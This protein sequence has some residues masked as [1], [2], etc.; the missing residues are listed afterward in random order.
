MQFLKTRKAQRS[1]QR[2]A[3]RAAGVKT[4]TGTL[5]TL[6]AFLS[7]VAHGKHADEL[8]TPELLGHW[9]V[10][11]PD[12][13]SGGGSPT[14]RNR[15]GAEP[16]DRYVKEKPSFFAPPPRHSGKTAALGPVKAAT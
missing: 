13:P 8:A 5:E 12:S 7:T 1:K 10:R 3:A 14:R 2:K 11:T 6:R 16:I 9:L 4:A 15:L